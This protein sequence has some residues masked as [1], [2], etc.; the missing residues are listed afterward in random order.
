MSFNDAKGIV[1]RIPCPSC[2]AQLQLL[3]G[4]LLQSADGRECYLVCWACRSKSLVVGD[5]VDDRWTTVTEAPSGDDWI[6]HSRTHWTRILDNDELHYWPTTGR[7][8]FRGETEKGDVEAFIKS[9][10]AA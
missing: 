6:K 10:E 9:V 8:R 4:R 3:I 7:Y 2:N 1:D 5:G